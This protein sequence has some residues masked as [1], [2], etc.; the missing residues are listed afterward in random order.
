MGWEDGQRWVSDETYHI[1]SSL[2]LLGRLGNQLWQIASVIGL[3]DKAKGL[4]RFME[5]WPYRRYFSIPDEFFE[6]V[7]VGARVQDYPNSY[8]QRFQDFAHLQQLIR[9]YFAPSEFA[10]EELKLHYPDALE[11]VAN[12]LA[13]HVRLTDYTQLPE[14]FVQLQPEYYERAINLA[15][16]EVSGSELLLFSDDLRSATR[17]L[18]QP[19]YL[20]KPR[21]RPYMADICELFLM[22]MC[23]GHVIANST[24]SWWGAFLADSPCV[25]YPGQW[26]YPALELYYRWEQTLPDDKRWKRCPVCSS[27]DPCGK[28]S[29]RL[30]KS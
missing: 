16:Q 13:V 6:L 5:A 7:P 14:L 18:R 15:R 3:A 2:T 11:R 20:I 21:S 27:S 25:V 12:G 22:S 10:I 17:M 24:F 4:A 29:P 8:M 19:H 26:A 23:R 30:E 1:F 28:K 9:Q